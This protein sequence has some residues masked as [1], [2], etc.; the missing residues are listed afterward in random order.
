[1]REASDTNGFTTFS[2]KS[3]F[4]NQN[5]RKSPQNS[6]LSRLLYQ[7]NTRNFAANQRYANKQSSIASYIPLIQ[8]QLR[9]ITAPNQQAS[10][11]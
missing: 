7:S 3:P 1:M 2:T 11:Q 6:Q 10:G 9:V 4:S 8:P 5:L